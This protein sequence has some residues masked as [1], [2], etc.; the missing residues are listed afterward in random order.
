M[1]VESPALFTLLV[2]IFG[3]LIPAIFVTGLL[4]L[5]MY[6][7]GR[8]T[9]RIDEGEFPGLAKGSFARTKS[10]APPA[11]GTRTY[12][13]FM[14]HHQRRRSQEIESVDL[15]EHEEA[16]WSRITQHLRDQER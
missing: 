15:S 2:A 8:R 16:E 12:F 6:W 1:V 14:A 9:G 7:W 10:T 4:I 13:L 5:G 11:P 3:L